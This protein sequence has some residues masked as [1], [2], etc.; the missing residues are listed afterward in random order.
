MTDFD[1]GDPAPDA[2]DEPEEDQSDGNARSET[3]ETPEP[4][5]ES[6]PESEPTSGSE[7]PTETKLN[8]DSSKESDPGE[9]GPAFPYSE[10]KQS[11]LYAREET[12]DEL[13]DELGITVTP[14]LR[15]M[16]IRDDELREVH[17][18]ILKVVLNH[19]DEVPEIV[20][21][22]RRKST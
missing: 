6:K 15:Q 7:Q 19:I 16:G 4:K 12:W 9:M 3:T 11:P 5:P 18:A 10:V 1:L 20:A 17:D 21:E 14:Q 8:D 2:D 22:E 13:E